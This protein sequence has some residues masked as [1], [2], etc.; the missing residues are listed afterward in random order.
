VIECSTA[1]VD[2]GKQN[3]VRLQHGD[4]LV[5]A[6]NIFTPINPNN[7]T[8][9]YDDLVKLAGVPRIRIHDQRHTHITLAIQAGANL[10]AVSKRVGHAKP[11]ITSDLYGHVTPEM[12][13]DVADRIAGVMFVKSP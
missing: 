1:G 2:R 11:S 4:M 5:F 3:E 8:R 9:D 10:L 13:A 12:H 6:S 7:L